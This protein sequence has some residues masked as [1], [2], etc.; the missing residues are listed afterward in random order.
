MEKYYLESIW[1]PRR[2]VEVIRI[3]KR[4]EITHFA[5]FYDRKKA[6]AFLSNLNKGSFD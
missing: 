2:G 4:G 5:V 1:N 3:F 6:E